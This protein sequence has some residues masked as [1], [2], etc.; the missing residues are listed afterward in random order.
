MCDIDI[1]NTIM[2][3]EL[4]FLKKIDFRSKIGKNIKKETNLTTN[5]IKLYIKKKSETTRFKNN[6]YDFSNKKINALIIGHII[7]YLF[8]NKGPSYFNIKKSNNPEDFVTLESLKNIPRLYFHSFYE[9]NHIF[10][11]DI[12]SLASFVENKKTKNIS[13]IYINPYTQNKLNI[14]T[15]KHINNYLLHYKNTEDILKMSKAQKIKNRAFTL[16]HHI[17][18]LGYIT[19]LKWFLDMDINQLKKWYKIG[20][21]V[22]NYRANLTHIEKNNIA[23]FKPPFIKNVTDVINIRS[24]TK[25]QDIVLDEI[26]YLILY[27]NDQNTQTLGCIYVLMIFT[28]INSNIAS[29]LP[30]IAQNY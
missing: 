29:A 22:W 6:Y 16:F 30:A 13:D 14:Y 18:S 23:P 2:K 17:D 8:K 19:D 3:Y 27:G 1:N 26:E 25:L 12:R 7:R 24:F 21:D 9:N 11:F 10:T 28:E 4:S 15:I 20:E 5:Q